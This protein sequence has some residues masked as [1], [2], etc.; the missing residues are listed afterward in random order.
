MIKIENL[1]K[2]V[3]IKMKHFHKNSQTNFIKKE[4]KR[5]KKEKSNHI[6]FAMMNHSIEQIQLKNIFSAVWNRTCVAAMQ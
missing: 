5:N 4:K 3:K 1:K 6:R 2:K